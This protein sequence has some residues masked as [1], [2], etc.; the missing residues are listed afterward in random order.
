MAPARS[1]PAL[2][3][4]GSLPP[5]PL[6]TLPL[7]TSENGCAELGT[8]KARTVIVYVPATGAASRTC[9]TLLRRS[10]LPPVVDWPLAKTLPRKVPLGPTTSRSRSLLRLAAA[11]GVDGKSVQVRVARSD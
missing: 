10:A 3:T 8:L 6:P 1:A 5:P 2:A 9:S 11:A 7:T 4:G